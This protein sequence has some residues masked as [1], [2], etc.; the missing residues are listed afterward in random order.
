MCGICGF[1]TKDPYNLNILEKMN[2]TLVH[3]GPDDNG[4]EIFKKDDFYF[5]LAQSRLSILDLS[6]MGHQPMH[7]NDSNVSIVFNGEIYNFI[8]LRE[9]LIA[10]GYRFR[11]NTD[12]E[13]IISAYQEW[14]T[15]CFNRLNGMFAIAIYDKSKNELILARDRIGK[16]PLYY[17]HKLGHFVFASELKAIMKYPEFV[18]EI[19]KDVISGYLYHQY[20]SAPNTIFK[21]TFKL[22]PGT[23]LVY[24]NNNINIQKYW[25][26]IDKYMDLN[27][28]LITDYKQAKFELNNLMIDSVS[29]RMISDVPLGSFLSGGID[30]SL[31]TAIAQSVSGKPIKTYSIGFEDPE[32][33]ESIFANEIAN[34]LGTQH[35]VMQINTDDM[36][37]LVESIP[38][39]YD[40]PFADAS[41]IPTMLV[42]QLARRDVT[43][44]LSGDGGDELFC[45]YNIYDKL[46]LAQK[47]DRYGGFLH[48]L[49]EETKM[50]KFNLNDKFPSSARA[51]VLNREERTKTQLLYHTLDDLP[52]KLVRDKSCKVLFYAEDKFPL[53][54]WQMRRMLLD[55]QTYLPED[56]LTKVDRASMKYSLEARCPIIDYRII[57]FSFQLPHEFKYY[58]GCKKRILK[59]LAFDYIPSR[60]LDRPKRGFGV[61]IDTWLKTSLS[62]NLKKFSERTTIMK[63]GIFDYELLSE[64]INKLYENKST[65]LENRVIWSFYVFQ[66]WYSKYIESIL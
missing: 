37:N 1:I 3:R 62:Y 26:I 22:E 55:M 30:S 51:V 39:Y 45:G 4:S 61:P 59:D 29:K 7:S 11:S 14:G 43:V 52:T 31:V 53:D 34:Y 64:L 48:Y 10:I 65:D 66:L 47:I 8:E 9:E 2:N 41:Q 44:A 25:D 18:K 21:D 49:L 33:D 36:V 35:T 12:T 17:Y 56:I 13:V 15:D 40:E 63:Q 24:K 42:S 46:P 27:N 6:E 32:Y 5:G 57:E 23:F 19:R 38:E 16:K 20:I 54:N 60:L 58:K 50:K 28:K